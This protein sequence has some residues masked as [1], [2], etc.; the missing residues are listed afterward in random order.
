MCGNVGSPPHPRGIYRVAAI[1]FM[2]PRFTPASAGNIRGELTKALDSEVHPRIRGEY[3]VVTQVFKGVGGSPPHPRGIFTVA[4]A[5]SPA[6][7]VTP[8]SAGNMLDHKTHR[9]Y[10]QV[11]P[12]IRGE[13]S[14]TVAE[15]AED[16]GFTPASAGNISK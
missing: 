4:F 13:Y 1:V 6:P 16:L 2:P 5:I 3:S 11:H 8:A 10:D 12:R 15:V 9:R 7:G 14:D